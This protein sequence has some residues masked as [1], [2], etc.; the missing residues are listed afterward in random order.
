MDEK[1]SKSII[2]P[3]GLHDLIEQYA[4]ENFIPFTTAMMEL[5]RA[6]LIAKKDDKLPKSEK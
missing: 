1:I 3:K 2:L 4:E 6:G 5:M